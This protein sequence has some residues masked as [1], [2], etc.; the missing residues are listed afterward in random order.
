MKVIKMWILK[1]LIGLHVSNFFQN[2]SKN[3]TS[4]IWYAVCFDFCYINWVR[5]I[6]WSE[7]NAPRIGTILIA[8]TWM[9]IDISYTFFI[10]KS[11]WFQKCNFQKNGLRYLAGGLQK[12]T[13]RFLKIKYC[14]SCILSRP[15]YIYAL[16]T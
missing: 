9:N 10:P 15:W 12:D 2:Q 5:A 8:R 1:V 11:F 6:F 3:L 4:F 14:N 7:S 13:P 16:K